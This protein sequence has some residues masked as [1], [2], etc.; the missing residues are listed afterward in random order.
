MR[1]KG[2]GR[3][4]LSN[5]EDIRYFE[6][7]IY[8]NPKISSKKC[9]TYLKR[10]EKKFNQKEQSVS[11]LINLVI[12]QEYHQKYLAYLQQTSVTEVNLQENGL[13]DI[14]QW[15]NVI[16]SDKTKISLVSSDGRDKVWKK[17]IKKV[18]QKI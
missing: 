18:K 1:I 17:S 6:N 10:S 14:K 15:E 7:L 11:Y 5:N 2:S 3:R 13:M 8:E 12:T 4:R 9:P 16:L